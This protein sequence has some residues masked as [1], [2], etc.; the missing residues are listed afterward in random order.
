VFKAVALPSTSGCAWMRASVGVI[1]MRILGMVALGAV[2]AG[3]AGTQLKYNTLDIASTVTALHTSQ[4]LENLSRTIDEPYALPSQVDITSGTIQTSN[5]ITPTV[6]SPLSRGSTRNAGGAFTGL[7]T[8]G[9]GLTVAAS[10]T[11]LQSWLVTPI[12]DSANLANI[13]ALY[14]Y[15]IYG[16]DP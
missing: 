7:T 3:C 1:Q 5:S 6:T 14:H 8:A 2:L 4:V 11:W 13:M 16:P 15:V 10:D 12:S 9:A